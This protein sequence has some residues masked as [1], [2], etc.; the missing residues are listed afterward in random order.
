MEGFSQ[1]HVGVG[2]IKQDLLLAFIFSFSLHQWMMTL[3]RQV[4][5]EEDYT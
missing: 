2:V 1:F 3:M 4:V 5:N